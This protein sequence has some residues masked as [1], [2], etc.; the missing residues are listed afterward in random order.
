MVQLLADEDPGLRLVIDL[1]D[2]TFWDSFGMAALLKAQ[3]MVDAIPAAKMIMAALPGQLFLRL[4]ESGLT[5]RFLLAETAD[6][7]AGQIGHT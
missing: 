4:R 1:G 2:L 3:A 6:Q 7:A 5:P